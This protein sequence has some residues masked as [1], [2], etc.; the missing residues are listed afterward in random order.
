M[1]REEEIRLIA[2]GI[3]ENEGRL[4]GHD[5][6][7]WLRAEVIWRRRQR[8]RQILSIVTIAVVLGLVPF[9]QWRLGSFQL[10]YGIIAGIAIILVTALRCWEI[11]RNQRIRIWREIFYL[12]TIGL[13]LV[14]LSDYERK[15]L[16]TLLK[17]NEIFL[18]IVF[19]LSFI[20]ILVKDWWRWFIDFIGLEG[21]LT[22]GGIVRLQL[23]SFGAALISLYLLISQNNTVPSVLQFSIIP[24]SAT[25]GGLVVAGANY[26]KISLELRTKL[27]KVA[28]K[29]I[30]ATIAF[31]FFAA[32]F[33]LAGDIKPEVIPS[34]QPEWIKYIS[35][36]VAALLF[37]LGTTLFVIGIFD[38]ALGL[39]KLKKE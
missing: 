30:V 3:W 33:S 17:S 23:S 28:Q 24:I 20:F 13:Y 36:W 38:L 37:Y 39:M 27:L 1:S 29:L 8:Q 34:T 9:L 25:L 31:I 6:E 22:I 2:H 15:S 21:P 35:F 19:A 11:C 16:G 32:I 4:S 10:V 12:V 5:I 18:W 26:S 7:N 14:L